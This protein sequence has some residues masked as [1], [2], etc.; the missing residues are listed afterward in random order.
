[1]DRV[2]DSLPA[3]VPVHPVGHHRLDHLPRGGQWAAA[4]RP[5]PDRRVSGEL[6]LLLVLCHPLDA[7]VPLCQQP[8][9]PAVPVPLSATAAPVGAHLPRPDQVGHEV[10]YTY[11]TI[12]LWSRIQSGAAF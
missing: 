10:T 2:R 5:V 1:M 9:L 11:H 12:S 3:A 6:C 7:R 4:S 8:A